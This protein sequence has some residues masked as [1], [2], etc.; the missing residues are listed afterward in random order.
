[1]MERY[2]DAY[3]PPEV[4]RLSKLGATGLQSVEEYEEMKQKRDAVPIT[5]K[6]RVE[7]MTACLNEAFALPDMK[8]GRTSI[9]RHLIVNPAGQCTCCGNRFDERHAKTT[10]HLQAV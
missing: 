4:H 7:H 6:R 10:K 9:P 5:L 2:G 3:V 8:A 1:M